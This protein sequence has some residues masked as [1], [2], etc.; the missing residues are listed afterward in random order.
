M[1][2]IKTK[3]LANKLNG[4]LIG[5]GDLSIIK[6]NKIADAK[7]GELTFLGDK[8][9]L[10][11][12]ESSAASCVLIKEEFESECN[13]SNVDYIVVENPHE[14]F[15]GLMMD[16]AANIKKDVPNISDRASIAKTAGLGKN[17]TIEP[18][19]V[20]GDD[21][22]IGDN[23]II[24]ANTTLYHNVSIGNNTCINS[25]V[26]IYQD[27]IIGKNCIIHS[28]A[29]IGAD[30]FGYIEH[31][32][33]SFTKVPQLG[34]VEIHNDVEI[35][36]NCTIDRAMIGST[37]IKSGVKLDNLVHI[38]HNCEIGENS[39]S[40]A[41]AGVSGS[42]IVGKRVRLGGQVGLAGHLSIADDV[43][44][45]AQSG[46][47]KTIDKKGTYFG[48][49]AKSQLQAFKI[50]AVIRHLPELLTELRELQKKVKKLEASDD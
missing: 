20:I 47:A 45:L 7:E 3:E 39:A 13:K 12:L 48:A 40:A 23:T 46:V 19:V 28:G 2:N 43:V 15:V 35:G 49:P 37:T 38:A 34:N 4:R 27:T 29:V 6:L 25:N 1:I 31:K 8:K 11:Y 42:A 9:Y 14:A 22:V 36:A 17:V 30:G 26:S 18:G 5:S 33:G 24:R 44:L 41:Q 32:D 10:H 16:I 50:E 21:C